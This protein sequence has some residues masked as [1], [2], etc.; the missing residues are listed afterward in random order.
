MNRMKKIDSWLD[1]GALASIGMLLILLGG[2]FLDCLI[3]ERTYLSVVNYVPP[4]VVCSGG[5]GMMVCGAS[6]IYLAYQK[7]K[8]DKA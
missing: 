5:I 4:F 3:G 1:R 8:K 7:W 6:C 2:N